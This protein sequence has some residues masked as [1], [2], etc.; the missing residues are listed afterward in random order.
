MWLRMDHLDPQYSIPVPQLGER[1]ALLD[2]L[3]ANALR[4]TTASL[5]DAP[6]REL[7]E[8]TCSQCHELPDPRQH[9]SEDWFVVVRRMNQHMND[10]LG[11]EAS[12]TEVEQIVRY[13]GQASM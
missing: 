13:L 11:H 8:T 4:V 5:P 2:Y 9:S 7:F 3:T 12:A 10:I 6:G 1:I